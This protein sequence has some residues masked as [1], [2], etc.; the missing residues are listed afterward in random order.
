MVYTPSKI[1]PPLKTFQWATKDNPKPRLAR[2]L[3][4]TGTTIFWTAPPYDETGTIITGDFLMGVKKPNGFTETIY[5]P[6]GAV[7]AD[8]LS[9]TGIVR[10][11]RLTGLDYTTGDSAYAD[12][13]EADEPVFSNISAVIQNLVAQN[14][15]F[16]NFANATERDTLIP[17]PVNGKSR[18]YLEDT[19]LYYLYAGGSWNSLDTGT[20]TPNASTTVA[21]KVELPTA[22]EVFNGTAIGSTGAALSVTPDTLQSTTV[23][24]N[25]SAGVADAGKLVKTASDGKI[26]GSFARDPIVRVYSDT[27]QSIGDGTTRFDLTKSG[28]TMTVTYDGT[29]TDPLITALAFPIGTIVDYYSFNGNVLN[30]GRFTITGSGANFVQWTNAS[31]VAQDNIVVGSSGR[32]FFNIIQKVAGTWT[33]PTGLT[34]ISIE[35]QGPGASGGASNEGNA[36]A[37]GG[38]G[39]YAKKYWIPASSLG[40]TETVTLGYGGFSSIIA[41]V[42]VNRSGGQTS[43]GS[44]LTASGGTAPAAASDLGGV[45][46]TGTGGDINI[47]GQTGGNA[48][49]VTTSDNNNIGADGG[50]S[51]LGFGGRGSGDEDVAGGNGI[52]FGSGGGGCEEQSSAIVGGGRGANGIVIL[53]EYY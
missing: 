41:S 43:F 25:S 4:L 52:G 45:G 48:I 13:H 34:G 10:G 32:G 7:A 24:K 33:K 51:T 19:G 17:S 37:G 40:A 27:A 14:L 8:G 22:T 36:T 23:S 11:V 15:V 12:T 1:F 9:A 35:V 30:N 42:A 2:G 50:S 38:A 6:A 44:L 18:A 39:G 20:V 26:D 53:T 29:G 3:T 28:N 46:G 16:P 49:N 21:G 47:T 5:I 31:G